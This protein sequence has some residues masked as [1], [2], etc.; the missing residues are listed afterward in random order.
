MKYLK[1]IIFLFS[2]QTINAQVADTLSYVKQFE[3]NKTNYIGKPFSVLLNDRNLIIPE[4]YKGGWIKSTNGVS[5]NIKN[6]QINRYGIK[7]VK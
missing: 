3:I 1:L 4:H 2:L 7:V 5:T 6:L